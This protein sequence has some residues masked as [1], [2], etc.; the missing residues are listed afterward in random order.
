MLRGAHRK[1]PSAIVAFGMLIGGAP[2]VL[3]ADID[4]PFTC[5]DINGDAFTDLNDFTA[6]HACVGKTPATQNCFCADM[7]GNGFVDLADYAQ[8]MIIFNHASD[9]APPNCTGAPATYANLTAHRPQNG[10][11]Y[12]PLTK[13]AVAE[14]DEENPTLGPG[15]RIN[16]PGDSDPAGEDDLIEVL[17]TVDPPGAAFG[18]RR[19]DPA[20]RAWTTR[21]KQAG[22]EIP[23]AAD[24]TDALPLGPADSELTLWIEWSGAYHGTATLDVEPLALDVV[25][26]TLT[27]HTFTSVV[28]VLGGEDQ[29]PSYP[30]DANSGT[31]VV[32]EALY[33]S[34]FDALLYDEDVVVAD[35]SGAAYNA[36]E[37][38]L[39]HRLV[40][41]VA[42]FGYSHG[43][44]ST[45]SLASR[46][47]VRRPLL[48][49]F[50]IHYTSYCDSVR[51]NSDVDVNQELRRPPST[52]YHLN[53]YQHGSLFQD[54]LLDGGPV[55]DSNPPPTGLDV[56]TTPWGATSTHFQ[57]DDYVQVRSAIESTLGAQIAR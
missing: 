19:S 32:G 33:R 48:G 36:V 26:D 16:G 14:A 21:T 1:I 9:E 49:V 7:D 2:R 11:G 37:D 15:I 44:G 4:C 35:G 6:F 45:Y 54:F 27:F 10:N 38:A 29:V 18:L 25:K 47:D 20:L 43:G 41:G 23:F 22:T 55:P 42:I 56:E 31:F 53:H 50:T 34:G 17:L 39:L 30:V 52:N 57:V 28:I 3:W 12:A 24:R 51:N 40:T 13:I 5:G 46:L 8:F